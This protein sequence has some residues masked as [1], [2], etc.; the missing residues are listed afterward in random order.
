MH[1]Q[2][3]PASQKS[4]IVNPRTALRSAEQ[5]TS[6]VIRRFTN[7]PTGIATASGFSYT[8]S[9]VTGTTEW[10]NVSGR[11]TEARVLSVS[12]YMLPGTS[13]TTPAVIAAVDRSG[14][15]A[16]PG[17]AVAAW[18]MANAQ[19]WFANATLARPPKLVAFAKDIEDFN[20]DPVGSMTSRF[21]VL[22]Y[23]TSSGT[24][25]FYTEYVVE[26]RGPR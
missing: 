17:S 26:L 13:L 11:Y 14:A 24:I 16:A 22:G 20:F 4:L 8:S 18:A 1:K 23:N 15:L 9:S 10:S 19:L 12:L 2:K 25:Q 3:N 6:S 21:S 5:S 7:I